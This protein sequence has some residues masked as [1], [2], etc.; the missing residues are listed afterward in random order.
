MTR[1]ANGDLQIA[2]SPRISQSRRVA[3]AG[4]PGSYRPTTCGESVLLDDDAIR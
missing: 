4:N 3:G 2:L 1:I